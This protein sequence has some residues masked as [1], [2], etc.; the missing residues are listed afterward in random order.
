M[1][2]QLPGRFDLRGAFGEPE[3]HGLM[4]EDRLAKAL[5]LLAVL[6][7]AF[8]GRTRH[9]HALRG[10]ADTP[11]LQCGKCNLVALALGPDQVRGGNAAVLEIDLRRIAAVLAQLVLQA[12]HLVAGIAA[13]LSVTAMTMA[14]SP[15]LPL[16]MNCLTPLMT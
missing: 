14:T 15:F 10:N 7:R 16:V 13:A 8:K 12:C 6:Q 5:A 4:V 1:P 9:A 3:A 11:A 2:Y